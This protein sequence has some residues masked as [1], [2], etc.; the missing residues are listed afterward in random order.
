MLPKNCLQIFRQEDPRKM[1]DPLHNRRAL[2]KTWKNYPK[3]DDPFS[4][5]NKAPTTNKVLW[6]SN[7]I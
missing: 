2:Q 5:G 4:K 6:Q 7:S 3:T 1:E